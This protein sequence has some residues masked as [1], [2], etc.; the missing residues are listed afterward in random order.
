[1]GIGSIKCDAVLN[2]GLGDIMMYWTCEELKYANFGDVMPFV[3][4]GDEILLDV[5]SCEVVKSSVENLS[6][7]N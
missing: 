1:M 3:E 2:E 4:G 7:I 6:R 5:V